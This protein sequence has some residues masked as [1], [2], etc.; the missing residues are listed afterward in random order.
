[1]TVNE[2]NV[3][4][5]EGY[6]AG[7]WPPGVKDQK[8]QT[9]VYATLIRAHAAASR[10]LRRSDLFDA[11]GDG[12]KTFIGLAHHVRI[13][14]AASASALDQTITGLSDDYFNDAVPRAL[15]SGRIYLNIPGTVSLDER[16][17]E[18]VDSTD[19]L[20]LNYYTRDFVRAD[21]GSKTLSKQYVPAGRPVNDL[22]WDEYPEGLTEMLVRFNRFNWP[23]VVTENGIADEHDQERAYFLRAHLYAVEEAI[24]RGADVRGYLHWSLIDNFEW[25]EGYSG[26]FGL[27]AIDFADPALRRVPRPSTAVFKEATAARR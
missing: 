14:Q 2:P 21:L 26:R 1:V 27:F 7:I 16:H 8:R 10:A 15:S 4:A 6:N 18:L 5:L 3:Y 12:K 11:D 23:L 20:G 13:F 22:G 9:A 19:W 25:A 24:R 17:P